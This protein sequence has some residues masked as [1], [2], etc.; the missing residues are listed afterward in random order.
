M[1][2]LLSHGLITTYLLNNDVNAIYLPKSKLYQIRFKD[3]YQF[4]N[5]TPQCVVDCDY[6]KI[7]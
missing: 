1:V 7:L 6:Y 5:T 2:D 4:P 3:L